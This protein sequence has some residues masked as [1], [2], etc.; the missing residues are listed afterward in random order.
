[1]SALGQGGEQGRVIGCIYVLQCRFMIQRNGSQEDSTL[2][3]DND[4]NVCNYYIAIQSVDDDSE[5]DVFFKKWVMLHT[6]QF[7]SRVLSTVSS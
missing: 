1:V 5:Y 2:F 7:S 4:E 3:Y 6:L